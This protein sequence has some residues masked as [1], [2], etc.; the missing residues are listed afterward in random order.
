M[1]IQ[2]TIP[3]RHE[4]KASPEVTRL[5]ENFFK[6]L[7]NGDYTALSYFSP[8]AD[9][10]KQTPDKFYKFAFITGIITAALQI[11]SGLAFM[12]LYKLGG[13]KKCDN[14]GHYKGKAQIASKIAFSTLGLSYLVCAPSTMGAG[15][16]SQQPGMVLHSVLAGALGVV[17]LMK[18]VNTRVK[19]LLSLAYA[20]LFAGFANKINNEFNA[21]PSAKSRKMDIDFII[22]TDSYVNLFSI[23]EKGKKIRKK[24]LDFM[25]FSLVDMKNGFTA[26]AQAVL[27]T[28]EQSKNYITRQ[29]KEL[30]DIISLKPTK[31]TMSLACTL[32]ILGSVP[33]VI[34]GDRMGGKTGRVA[35]FLIGAGF[36]F[37]SLAM[38][39]MAKANDD[40]RKLPMLLGAPMRIIGD[41]RQENNFFY[42]LRTIG[43]AAF[44]Y[45]Y[46]LM[47]KEK[48][49]KL[50]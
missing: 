40:D 5:H 1:D 15:I 34:L 44:E 36:L 4:L 7:N 32:A 38:M 9:E 46:A 37:D 2:T 20:P 16:N 22:K 26:S 23:G 11:T 24:F 47:N 42:G 25:K 6:S 48:D 49:G 12:A 45:Y 10:E 14:A 35:D 30:P 19:G 33:K 39:S 18:N 17:S 3:V 21:S 13:K 28:L 27:K 8:K 31:E 41:F 29:R 43:G 50:L